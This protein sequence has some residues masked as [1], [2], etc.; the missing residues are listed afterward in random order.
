MSTPLDSEAESALHA[1]RVTLKAG[2]DKSYGYSYKFLREDVEFAIKIID[3]YF[4][5]SAGEE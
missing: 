5:L 1:V 2:I 3:A 4:G